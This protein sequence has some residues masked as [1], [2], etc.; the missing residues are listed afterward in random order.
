ME[1]KI[2]GTAMVSPVHRV[3][4]MPASND[5]RLARGRGGISVKT[6]AGTL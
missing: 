6:V 1:N 4:A 3:A 5:I 2:G